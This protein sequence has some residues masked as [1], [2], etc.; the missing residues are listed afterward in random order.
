MQRFQRLAALF[1]LAS[2]MISASPARAEG[3]SFIPCDCLS[4][5]CSCFIQTG[6]EGGAVVRIV[7]L[8]IEKNYLD[9]DTPTGLFSGHVETAVKRFQADHGLD[10]T[11]T[12]DDDTL[13][14]LLWGM[15]PETVDEKYEHTLADC[16]TVYLPTDGG[17]KRHIDPACSQ[18]EDPRK[19]SGRNAGMLGFDRCS[20][21]SR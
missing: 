6:D 9:K 1:L 10:V 5:V 13:T 17:K 8:L 4:S 16:S 3:K 21:C 12:M 11:G 14:L 19:V 15:L 20:R 2:M 7:E 18:M